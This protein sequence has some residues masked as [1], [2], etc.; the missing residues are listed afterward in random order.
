VTLWYV[1]LLILTPCLPARDRPMAEFQAI[2]E[3]RSILSTHSVLPQPVS[4]APVL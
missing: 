1:Q 2:E 3:Q 4:L